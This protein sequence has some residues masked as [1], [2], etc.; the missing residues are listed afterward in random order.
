MDGIL[1]VLIVD[2]MTAE[3]EA[4][5]VVWRHGTSN[6]SVMDSISFAGPNDIGQA[7]VTG[8]HG[9]TSAGGYAAQTH[10][11][12]LVANDAGFGRDD[13]GT[14]GLRQLAEHGIPA[15]AAAHTSARIGDGEDTWLHGIVSFTNQAAA[16]LGATVGDSVQ[17]AVTG[18]IQEGALARGDTVA[19][20]AQIP[21]M[22]RSVMQ[23][24]DGRTVLILDSMSQVAD[25]DRNHLIIAA[26]NGGHASG[27]VAVLAQC[28]CVIWNDAGNGKDAAGTDGLSMAEEADIAAATVGHQSARIS[29]GVDTWRHGVISAIN[30]TA[31]RAGLRV[32]QPVQSALAC[33][34]A[35]TALP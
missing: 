26:S 4:A 5:R 14:A 31:A 35:P 27:A 19:S 33:F 18:L 28:R 15:V 7:V 3:A 22:H 10:V 17:E 6:V 34:Y 32:G 25:D 29:D 11:G 23:L 8:S 24:P 1:P 21:P 9:G 30:S 2:Q 16:D 20:P 13:A 12:L